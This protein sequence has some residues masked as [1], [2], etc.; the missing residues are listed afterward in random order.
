MRSLEHPNLWPTLTLLWGKRPPK[1]CFE[2]ELDSTNHII[3]IYSIKMKIYQNEQLNAVLDSKK[4][5]N[6]PK[7]TWFTI[8]TVSLLQKTAAAL[9]HLFSITIF[10]KLFN[11]HNMW[12][13]V[14][15]PEKWKENIEITSSFW[16]TQFCCIN[17]CN[18]SITATFSPREMNAYRSIIHITHIAQIV[19]RHVPRPCTI[20]KHDA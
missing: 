7:I 16:F 13:K 2:G 3:F 19:L 20:C 15:F 11:R 17:C 14:F 1:Q 8:G 6:L 12:L 18:E 10:V 5:H 9:S 4:W